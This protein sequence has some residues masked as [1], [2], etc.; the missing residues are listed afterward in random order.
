[1]GATPV[2]VRL[3][4]DQLARLDAWIASLPDPKPTR[5]EAIRRALEVVMRMG[6]PDSQDDGGSRDGN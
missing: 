3:L 4:P 2:T 1:M 6:G 5:P